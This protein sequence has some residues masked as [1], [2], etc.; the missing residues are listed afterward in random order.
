VVKPALVVLFLVA[1]CNDDR[2]RVQGDIFFCNPASK[3][4]N[5][6]CGDGYVCYTA[7]QSVGGSIC[8]PRCDPANEA[9][10]CPNGRCTR[11][12]ECL[13]S[14]RVEDMNACPA[15][16]HATSC[17]RTDYSPGTD[18]DS[19]DDGVCLPVAFSCTNSES[20]LGS[21]VFNVCTSGANGQASDPG[22]SQG[23]SVCAQGGCS[24]DGVACE[25]GSTCIKN[26]FG[27][28]VSDAPDVC[29]PNCIYQT[30]QSDMGIFQCLPGFNCLNLAFPQSGARVCAPGVPGWRCADSLGCAAG[31]CEPWNG[32]GPASVEMRVCTPHCNHDDDCHFYDRSVPGLP[33]NP[34]FVSHFSCV[35]GFCRALGPLFI[36]D[37]CVAGTQKCLLD[38]DATCQT[39]V[40]GLSVANCVH[41]CQADKECD[42]LT[43]SSHVKHVCEPNSRICMASVPF[44][45]GCNDDNSCM[46][47]LSC[48]DI[49]PMK[50]C[51][52]TCQTD[53][54]CATHEILGTN[55]AC[56]LPL[57]ICFPKAPA[58]SPAPSPSFCLS[59]QA[60]SGTCQSPTGWAC[61]AD[62]ECLS[63]K[64]E[65]QHCH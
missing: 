59:G 39:G 30:G 64:C 47:G 52:A 17:V 15:G 14:C 2:K 28:G 1:G 56:L 42:L 8:V 63:G 32:V 9:K 58:G 62:G 57:Q 26:V 53:A 25:P 65:N 61:D 45:T 44:A 12:G 48:L 46:P 49:G 18:K 6:D 41:N 27:S 38:P 43:Q 7:T 13:T 24:H 10:T 35:R 23:G 55:F 4:A 51:S 40:A 5:D 11:A 20:C 31:T 34:S 29:T 33:T 21:P 19:G 60:P 37:A 16:N 22:L 3:S 50:T 36:T 54:D